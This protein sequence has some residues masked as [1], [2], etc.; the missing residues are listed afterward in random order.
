MPRTEKILHSRLLLVTPDIAYQ[1][2]YEQ[3]IQELGDEER[4]PFPMDFE[5]QDFPAMLQR[6]ADFKA[7]YNLPSGYVPSSTYWLV[8]G[9]ELIGVVNIRHYL[10][11]ALAQAGGHIGLSIRPSA[12]GQSLGVYLLQQGVEKA[13]SLG[14]ELIHVHC[15]KSNLASA[16]M[17]KRCGGRL[18]SEWSEHDPVIQRYLIASTDN[19]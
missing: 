17:I 19:S 16:S 2:S 9:D 10:N 5:H 4:Y 7:G 12:R 6:I 11:E 18:H 13:K 14:I 15:Y 3:Y 8:C 1:A